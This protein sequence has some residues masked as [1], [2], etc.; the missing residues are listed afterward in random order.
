VDDLEEIALPLVIS[1]SRKAGF[2]AANV[3]VLEQ[4]NE[5]TD[6]EDA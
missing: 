1:K 5:T 2:K 6:S 3:A 4:D